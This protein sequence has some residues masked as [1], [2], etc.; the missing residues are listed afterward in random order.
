MALQLNARVLDHSLQGLSKGFWGALQLTAGC[1]TD[2]IKKEGREEAPMWTWDSARSPTTALLGRQQAMPEVWGWTQGTSCFIRTCE[3]WSHL[4]FP[5]QEMQTLPQQ[6]VSHGLTQ[7]QSL[8]HPSSPCSMSRIM[9]KAA[10]LSRTPLRL[11]YDTIQMTSCI[12]HLTFLG[13]FGLFFPQN[14]FLSCC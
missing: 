10:Y 9:V 3:F 2:K 7:E 6:A 4:P 11:W 14:H 8:I 13:R 5:E 1:G 12:E